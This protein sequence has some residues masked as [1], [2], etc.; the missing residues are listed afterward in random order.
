MSKKKIYTKKEIVKYLKILE[1]N[2]FNYLS[3]SKSTGIARQTLKNWTDRYGKDVFSP[4]PFQEAI[5][6][7]E[8]YTDIDKTEFRNLLGDT[9]TKILRRM[10]ILIREERNL[11]NLQ[12]A[13]R[14]LHEL[15]QQ[16]NPS[17]ANRTKGGDITFLQ[18]INQQLIQ[19]ENNEKKSKDEPDSEE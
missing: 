4:D 17:L 3:T 12:K 1:G 10:R 18:Y 8:E 16:D 13:L 15:E 11:D 5:A 7:I 14:T 19:Q 2:K 6:T 9:Q